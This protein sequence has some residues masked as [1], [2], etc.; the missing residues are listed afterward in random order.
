MTD[1]CLFS[2]SS[3]MEKTS[4]DPKRTYCD[5]SPETD[6]IK[7]RQ[8]C[9]V[10]VPDDICGPTKWFINPDVIYI[11]DDDEDG[12]DDPGRRKRN[13]DCGLANAHS[14]TKVHVRNQGLSRGLK[15]APPTTVFG[16][17]FLGFSPEPFLELDPVEWNRGQEDDFM[18]I[19]ESKLYSDL[20]PLVD[21]DPA[22]SSKYDF[23]G[24]SELLPDA[25]DLEAMVQEII[26]ETEH[27]ATENLP[28][29]DPV[30]H[31]NVINIAD[32]EDGDD[33]GA[34][35]ETETCAPRYDTVHRDQ[36]VR[37]FPPGCGSRAPRMEPWEIEAQDDNF[38]DH[39][40]DHYFSDD[41]YND[42]SDGDFNDFDNDDDM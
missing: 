34:A 33:S 27:G 39:E 4:S 3:S 22:S 32:D 37:T 42:F 20:A 17:V 13:R 29:K 30:L 38:S 10:K 25:W 21:T 24:H 2:H 35:P 5:V 11:S 8:L 36:A 41:S 16:D 7:R 26:G 23:L 9:C 15:Q 31:Q 1:G 14:V 6:N 28:L 18:T 40:S 12:D 19:G